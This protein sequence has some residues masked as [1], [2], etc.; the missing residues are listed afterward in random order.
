MLRSGEWVGY[1]GG[2]S[3]IQAGKRQA[4]RPAQGKHGVFKE[5]AAWL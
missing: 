3:G 2:M 4:Q 5:V 1:Y